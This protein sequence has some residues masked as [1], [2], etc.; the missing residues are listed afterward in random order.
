M[1]V[2]ELNPDFHVYCNIQCRPVEDC[3]KQ[4]AQCLK[5]GQGRA[6]VK[7][8][9]NEIKL[10]TATG[11]TGLGSFFW[12]LS[13]K[14]PGLEGSSMTDSKKRRTNERKTNSGTTRTISS[15]YRC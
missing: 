3:Q 13:L 6:K 14:S 8:S 12:N 4:R 1:I 9:K 11:E 2:L 10:K 7:L 5:A 15:Y